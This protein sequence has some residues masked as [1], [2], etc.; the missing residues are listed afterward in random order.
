M[1]Q[2]DLLQDQKLRR[3]KNKFNGLVQGF[4]SYKTCRFN[5]FFYLH[6]D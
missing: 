3:L 1:Y 6:T 5:L 4:I 2:L